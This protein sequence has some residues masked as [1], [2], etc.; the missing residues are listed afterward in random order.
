MKTIAL[1][2]LPLVLACGG[3]PPTPRYAV[4]FYTESDPGQSLSGVEILAN[5][6]TVGTSDDT[7]LVQAILEGREGTQFSIGWNCPE[8]Y[9]APEAAQTLRLRSFQGLSPDAATGLTM[10]LGCPPAVRHAGFV[11][12]TNGRAG[13][14]VAL[15][16]TEVARTNSEGVA[17]F[18]TES[19]PGV[20]YRV[21]ILTED[22]SNLR[23][24]SPARTFPLGDADEVF[25]F[26]QSFETRRGAGRRPRVRTH[27]RSPR[28]G[29]SRMGRRRGPHKIRRVPIVRTF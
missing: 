21:Q 24:E 22:G 5:G 3:D 23:P 13:L 2:L 25:V 1:L 8:G 28:R 6:Q 11:V 15:N 12:R 16:G 7:G 18:A 10:A 26:S 14:A 17:Q 29:S 4:A 9:R 27:G 20:A 19:A